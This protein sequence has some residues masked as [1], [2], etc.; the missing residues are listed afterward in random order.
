M[1]SGGF[2]QNMCQ[3]YRCSVVIIALTA[4]VPLHETI[5]CRRASLQTEYES[6]IAAMQNFPWAEEHNPGLATAVQFSPATPPAHMPEPS[7]SEKI[8]SLIRMRIELSINPAPN[9]SSDQSFDVWHA[10]LPPNAAVDI[11]TG[12]AFDLQLNDKLVEIITP[13]AHLILPESGAFVQ[14]V[15]IQ[16]IYNCGF[17]CSPAAYSSDGL[18]HMDMETGRASV[19][20]MELTS[21][22]DQ[23]FVGQLNFSLNHRQQNR[24]IDQVAQL[25]F[26]FANGQQNIWQAKVTGATSIPSKPQVIGGFG[27]A[28]AD[29]ARTLLGHFSTN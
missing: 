11:K 6:L 16:F 5:D 8:D 1:G 29:H 25:M 24:F 18:L 27:A 10:R 7:I 13:A 15:A 28:D 17:D 26:R 4:C 22:C 3:I 20:A 23:R 12:L 14:P 9:Q 21:L 19:R 2:A